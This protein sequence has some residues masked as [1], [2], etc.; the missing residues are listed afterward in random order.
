MAPVEVGLPSYR[1]TNFD[2]KANVARLEDS[3]DLLGEIRAD[4]EVRVVA[5]KWKAEQYFNKRVKPRSF[6]VGNLVLKET[7]V[8]LGEEGKLGPLMGRSL[9]WSGKS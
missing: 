5:S 6:K 4:V 3:L 8:T 9:R 1:R 2:P 7:G